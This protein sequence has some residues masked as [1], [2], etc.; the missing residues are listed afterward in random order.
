R[1]IVGNSEC[2]SAGSRD[3]NK[4]PAGAARVIKAA[5]RHSAVDERRSAFDRGLAFF[6]LRKFT[7]SG[8]FNSTGRG[9]E[10]ASQQMGTNERRTRCAINDSQTERSELGVEISAVYAGDEILTPHHISEIFRSAG[11]I[12]HAQG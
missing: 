5:D 6:L 9:A 7:E 12:D 1:K 11:I 8:D 4:S 2:C 10:H 3:R